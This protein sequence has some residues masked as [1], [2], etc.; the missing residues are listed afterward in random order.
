MERKYDDNDDATATIRQDF[1]S[2]QLAKNPLRFCAGFFAKFVLR[3]LPFCRIIQINQL[4]KR[5]RYL[6]GAG[7]GTIPLI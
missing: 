1:R 2:A 4:Q 7:Q 5:I 3:S 6:I